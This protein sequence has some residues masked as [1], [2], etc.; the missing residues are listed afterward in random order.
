VFGFVGL[1]GYWPNVEAVRWFA[2][3]VL[4]HIRRTIPAAEFRVVGRHSESVRPLGALPGVTIVGDVDSL[5][6]ELQRTDASVVPIRSG[7]GTRL[8]VV[9]AMANRLPIVSTTIGCEGI[10]VTDREHLLVADDAESFAAACVE[11]VTDADVRAALIERAEERYLEHYQWSS[12]RAD[13]ARL[14]RDV[15]GGD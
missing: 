12:I 15:A 11:I 7:A 14:A 9:E 10:D 4:P 2:T 8:K 5:Q 6:P 1:L 3:D 13:V